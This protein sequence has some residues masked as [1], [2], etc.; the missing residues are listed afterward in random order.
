M[1]KNKVKLSICGT[2]YI[3]SADEDEEYIRS[4][5]QEVERQIEDALQEH[6]RLSITTAS[7]LTALSCC[8]EYHKA[9]RSADN[10]RAQIKEY[11]ADAARSRSEADEA[12]R[13]IERLKREVQ[14]LRL[15]IAGNEAENAAHAAAEQQTR[16]NLPNPPQR[17]V[18]PPEAAPARPK[19]ISA[20]DFMSLFDN[21]S[22]GQ[23]GEKKPT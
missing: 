11:L 1:P 5:A 23:A 8:D 2:D 15:R 9:A 17:P 3:L 10:L 19:E 22:S 4:I 21:F 6:A 18:T 7:V 13:E 20:G 14:S 12:R 16:L